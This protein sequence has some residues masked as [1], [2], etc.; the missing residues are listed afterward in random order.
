MPTLNKAK[1]ET[2][3][4]IKWG[5]LALGIILVI[6]MAVKF[7]VFVKNASS[8][9]PPPDATFGKLPPIPFPK[10]K[11]ENL[12]YTLDTLTGSLP[13]FS[14]RAK[15]YRTIPNPPTL[16]G[17]DKSR[18]RVYSAGFSS[19]DTQVSED[20]YKWVDQNKALARTMTMNI[21][22]SEF[23]LSSSY[24]S[25]ASLKTISKS[26]KENR[27]IDTAKTFL[28]DMS[29]FPR[30]IDE[31]KTKITMY[32]ISN[33]ALIPTSK[34]SDAKIM[35]V[36]FFQKDLDSLQIYYDRG[37][38]STIDLLIGKE[39]GG[40]EVVAGRFY[41][42]NLSDK[43]ST[44]AI[45]TAKEA[46]SE[47]QQGQAYVAYKPAD[48]VDVTI[49]KVFLGYY[50]GENPQDYLMPIIIFE[51]NGNFLAYVSAVKDEWISN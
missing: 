18:Q 28:S 6:F 47:L 5:G 44:Y 3:L 30:D 25:A 19:P 34:I 37:I 10:Q 50:A 26:D 4:A 7:V 33:N 8:P 45:K 43:F 27:L 12:T 1:R 21:Y 14:D 51:G 16:L 31:S 32:S 49:T 38:S 15:I 13:L 36:A 22:S 20:T 29:L 9:P 42:K 41:H 23:T 48:M 17:L 24:L 2:K 40:L 11:K 46:Y 35:E 39:N